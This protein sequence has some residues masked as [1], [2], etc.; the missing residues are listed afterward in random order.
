MRLRASRPRL[1]PRPGGL[2]ANAVGSLLFPTWSENL[3][4]SSTRVCPKHGLEALGAHGARFSFLGF[5]ESLRREVRSRKLL[6]LRWC[7]RGRAWSPGAADGVAQG[8]LRPQ[9]GSSWRP[10]ATAGAGSGPQSPCVSAETRVE[11]SS[12]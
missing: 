8:S 11:R 5:R 4:S 9:G 7:W 6:A 3:A 2:P 10:R 1:K 12:S